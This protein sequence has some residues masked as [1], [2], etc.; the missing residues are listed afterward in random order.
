MSVGIAGFVAK[1]QKRSPSTGVSG[2]ICQSTASVF[3][4]LSSPGGPSFRRPTQGPELDLVVNYVSEFCCESS[5]GLRIDCFIEPSIESGFPDAVLVHWDPR[6]TEG[7][8]AARRE[9]RIEDLRLL[10]LLLLGGRSD[11]KSLGRRFGAPV[12]RSIERLRAAEVVA[13]DDAGI[14][15]ALPLGQ[16][17]AVKRLV[18]IEAKMTGRIQGLMQAARNSWFA[19]ESFYLAGSRPGTRLM[20]EADKLGVGLLSVGVPLDAPLVRPTLHGLPVSYVSWL[21]NEWAWR[22]LG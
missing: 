8:P 7:W 19:S 6:A 16:V 20:I 9:L 15:G 12:T 21:F 10:Q 4:G 22:A 3:P 1:S 18:A 13:V 2:V 17:F 14:A 5:S 11:L